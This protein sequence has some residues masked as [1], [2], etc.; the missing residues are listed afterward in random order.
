MASM[1][2]ARPMRILVEEIGGIGHGDDAVILTDE[3][4]LDIS[5]VLAGAL[6]SA[7]A[8]AAITVIDYEIRGAVEPTSM[9]TAVLCEADYGFVLTGNNITHTDVH[10]EA[11][12][13]GTQISSMWGV[14]ED[15]FLHGP[16]PENYEEVDQRIRDIKGHLQGTSEV[17]IESKAGTDITFDVTDRPVLALGIKENDKTSAPDYPQGEVAVAPVEGTASG[18]VIVDVGVDVIGLVDEP[19]ELE[20]EEGNV[21]SIRGGNEARELQRLVDQADKNATNLA[22]FAVGT[23][24]E[25]RLVDHIRET[26]K[27]LGTIHLA[28]GDNNTIGG[29]VK[30]NLHMDSIIANPTIRFDDRLIM[31]DGDLVYDS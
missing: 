6:R 8:T 18:T 31:D 21:V 22:E 3:T 28:I 5:R 13:A 16:S 1:E 25:A 30:S 19:I 11:Q 20:F 12:E 24:A 2:L 17:S 10:R 26:K 23:N 29:T 15:T 14:S 27:R 9:A 7:G 4:R